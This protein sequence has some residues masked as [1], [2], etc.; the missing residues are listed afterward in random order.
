MSSLDGAPVPD[1]DAAMN[2]NASDA[3]RH[4]DTCRDRA[5]D[6]A[7]AAEKAGLPTELHWECIQLVAE[8]ERIEARIGEYVTALVESGSRE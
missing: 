8:A 1:A 7:K 6:A 3:V 4:L 2:Q 5:R